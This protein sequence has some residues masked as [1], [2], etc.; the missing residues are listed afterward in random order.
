MKVKVAY[1]VTRY[2]EIEIPDELAN[3]YKE[4]CERDD[5]E[6]TLNCAYERIDDYVADTIMQ[7]DMDVECL[8][9]VDWEE[10]D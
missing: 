9:W 6:D 7:I 2:T 5:D 3:K 10:I 1:P 8:D 4:A